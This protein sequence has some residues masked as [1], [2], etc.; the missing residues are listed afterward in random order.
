[1][2]KLLVISIFLIVSF[3]CKKDKVDKTTDWLE[4]LISQGSDKTGKF[5]SVYS[6]K[7]NGKTV[8]LLNYEVKC[9][10][11]FTSQLFDSEGN[12][13]CFPYG[14]ITGHGDKKCEDFDISKSDEKLY[15]KI[16][17]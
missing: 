16:G 15:W 13:I 6:Y 2:K 7:F 10:D 9:C 3:S 17:M 14:G 4:Q 8:Y 11:N 5:K 12:S 1:M